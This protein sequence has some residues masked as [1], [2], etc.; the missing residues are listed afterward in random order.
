MAE[1][2]AELRERQDTVT[3]G[4]R[5]ALIGRKIEVLVDAAGEGRSHREAPEIDGIVQLPTRI[6]VGSFARVQVVDALGPD[7]VAVEVTEPTVAES[8]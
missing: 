1:R 3:A 4:R 2:L 7:L 5:D 8:R 6:P